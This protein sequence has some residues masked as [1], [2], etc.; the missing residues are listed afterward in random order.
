M[1]VNKKRTYDSSDEEADD[2]ISSSIEYKKLKN[3][4]TIFQ[5]LNN[6]RTHARWLE[7]A[8]HQTQTQLEDENKEKNEDTEE[9]E[10]EEVN[11]LL[12]HHPTNLADRLFLYDPFVDERNESDC[13]TVFEEIVVDQCE[14]PFEETEIAKQFAFD[15]YQK[16]ANSNEDSQYLE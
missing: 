11:T 13:E 15:L 7:P 1:Q 8:F 2:R 6:D 10:Q 3:K 14:I 12:D 16:I 9:Q 4:Y 5:R